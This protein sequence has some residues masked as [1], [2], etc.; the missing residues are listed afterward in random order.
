MALRPPHAPRASRARIARGRQVVQRKCFIT[1]PL[2]FGVDRRGAP[3]D[4]PSRE[5]SERS[6]S[7]SARRP[8]RT[9]AAA[10]PPASRRLLAI[11]FPDHAALAFHFE[12]RLPT[13]GL[14]GSSKTP[15][16]FSA[17][18]SVVDAGRPERHALQLLGQLERPPRGA[19]G[20][21]LGLVRRRVA[22]QEPAAQVVVVPLVRLDRVP[23]EPR[24]RRVPGR[25]TEFD[26]LAILHDG[27]RLPGELTG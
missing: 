1:S 7:L 6:R 25:L 12:P 14:G 2:R 20:G 24:G 8:L 26:E 13:R 19:A 17:A 3:L 15:P 22:E 11:L 23:V 4:L 9:T 27:D 21:L 5:C 10:C 16:T 18:W